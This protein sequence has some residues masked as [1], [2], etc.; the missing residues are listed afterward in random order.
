MILK[1]KHQG[2]AFLIV[3]FF[4]QCA[5]L[6]GQ[7]SITWVNKKNVTVKNKYISKFEGGLLW[8]AGATSNKVLG[9]N[10]DGWMTAVLQ[11]PKQSKIIGLTK[12]TK[13]ANWEKVTYGIR[14]KSGK[15]IIVEG[16]KVVLETG[17]KCKKGDIV[18]I[19][20]VGATISYKI[21]D[22]LLYTSKK[23]VSHNLR[24]KV[25]FFSSGVGFLN[26]KA[27]NFISRKAAS[28]QKSPKKLEPGEVLMTTYMGAFGTT[29]EIK[30]VNLTTI[31][32]VNAESD[33]ENKVISLVLEKMTQEDF[34]II[35]EK[36]KWIKILSI[37]RSEKS[38]VKSL[39]A[40]GKLTNIEDVYFINGSPKLPKIDLAIFNKSVQ[41]KKLSAIR[42]TRFDN[43]ELLKNLPNLE[44]LELIQADLESIEFL[45]DLTDL[46]ELAISGYYDTFDNLEPVGYLKK[47]EKFNIR[48]N[49]KINN[50][51][52]LL[53]CTNLKEIEVSRFCPRSEIEKLKKAFP[54]IKG[55][56]FGSSEK[57]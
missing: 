27:K 37:S 22:E 10:S 39:N 53:K 1:Q 43:Y 12:V 33:K 36:L 5:I 16:D 11:K 9:L 50:L 44:A 35:C 52:P 18:K 51:D 38:K 41:L 34:D 20:K 32:A 2:F 30:G 40:L 14:F 8:D 13:I 49:E 17:R 56:I 23:D 28:T 46:K 3:C 6:Y 45:K 54:N 48:D 29:I 7:K 31:E 57:F 15:A 26:A 4:A 42:F 55:K 24:V 47:L 21:N 19:E 25:A